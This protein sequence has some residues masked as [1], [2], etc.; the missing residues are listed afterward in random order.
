MLK[1]LNLG[2]YLS[3]ARSYRGF[4]ARMA[5]LINDPPPLLWRAKALH[6]AGFLSTV[7]PPVPKGGGAGGAD[8]RATGAKIWI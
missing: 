8:G 3:Q 4:W 6:D 5:G 7:D 1:N 2:D